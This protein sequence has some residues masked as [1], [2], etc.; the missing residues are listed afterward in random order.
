RSFILTILL[1]VSLRYSEELVRILSSHSN[2]Q[3][4]SLSMNSPASFGRSSIIFSTNARGIRG[5][6]IKPTVKEGIEFS[7][8]Y[9][10]SK[11]RYYQPLPFLLTLQ[12]YKL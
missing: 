6:G 3:L 5:A 9:Y 11:A 1:I 4:Q 10:L 8:L 2:F 12:T 7:F